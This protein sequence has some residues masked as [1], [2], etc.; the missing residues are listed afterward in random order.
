MFDRLRD[1]AELV[2]DELERL[3]RVAHPAEDEDH[4][5]VQ[6][7]RLPGPPATSQWATSAPGLAIK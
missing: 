7:L 5:G 1:I 4:L 2:D 6:Q 3:L